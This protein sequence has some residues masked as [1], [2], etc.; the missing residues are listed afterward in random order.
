[1]LLFL[2]PPKTI[3]VPFKPFSG[4]EFSLFQWYLVQWIEIENR[5]MNFLLENALEDRCF[6]LNCPRELNDAGK[7]REMFDFFGVGMKGTE[8]VFGGRKNKSIGYSAALAEQYENESETVLRQ[9]PNRY[10]QIFRHEP[11]AACGWNGR[12]IRRLEREMAVVQS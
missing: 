2:R 7:I 3:S 10:L 1:M 8:I 12:F 4:A 6:T 5:A 11:Y 9:M